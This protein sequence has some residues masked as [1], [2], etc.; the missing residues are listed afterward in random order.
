MKGQKMSDT[1]LAVI[2]AAGIP[3]AVIGFL[4]TRLNKKLDKR[5]EDKAKKE[6]AALENEVQLIGLMMATLSLAE[7]TAEAVQRI[8]DANC[9]G[10]MHEALTY[11]KEAKQ[12]Y[13]E[14]ERKQAVRAIN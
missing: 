14:F 2:L 4:I 8:P 13:R 6:S 7:A 11:A 3:S 9:N 1:L 12:K 5:E 10:D